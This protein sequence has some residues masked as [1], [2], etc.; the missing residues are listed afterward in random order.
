MNS[1]SPQRFIEPE[2]VASHF[3]IHEGDVVADFGAGSGYFISTLAL[4][5]GPKGKVIACE[6]QKNLV[7]KIGFDARQLGYNNIDVLWSDLEEKDGIPI[8][9]SS[10]DAGILV[11]TFFQLEDKATAVREI[12]RVIRSGGVIHVIEWNDSYG[13]IGPAPEQVVDKASLCDW[14]EADCFVLER[15]YPAGEH[16]YGVT[17]RAI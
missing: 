8:K 14:F 15:E 11:N 10:L 17:F 3:H 9:E 13:G 16:H 6:I 12:C 2:V 5:V 7:E 4:A 1:V